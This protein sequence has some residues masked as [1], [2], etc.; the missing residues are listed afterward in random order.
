MMFHLLELWEQDYKKLFG[1][2]VVAMVYM[3]FVLLSMRLNYFMDVTTAM[4][5][6]HYVYYFIWE[7]SQ[8]IDNFFFAVYD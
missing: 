5:F 1:L 3:L 8:S 4:V 7:R 2:Q 6:G